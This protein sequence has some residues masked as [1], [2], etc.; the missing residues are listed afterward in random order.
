MSI[1]FYYY[2]FFSDEKRYPKGKENTVEIDLNLSSDFNF[3]FQF[4]EPTDNLRIRQLERWNFLKKHPEELN[5]LAH[6]F[7]KIY[8]IS[9]CTA[10]DLDKA[11]LYLKIIRGKYGRMPVAFFTNDEN[12]FIID[13][14]LHYL[15]LK[16]RTAQK[17]DYLKSILMNIFKNKV[18][19]YYDKIKRVLYISFIDAYTQKNQEIFDICKYF[20]ADLLLHIEVRWRNYPVII[21][22]TNYAIVCE[23]E[24]LCGT[25][26]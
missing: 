8:E 23:G 16:K 15:V 19:F 18:N 5:I 17:Y 21:D 2:T 13:K 4:N 3:L 12:D 25:I 1:P 7:R 22:K 11:G 9:D 26:L 14:I 24:Q 10:Y 6:L 20:F